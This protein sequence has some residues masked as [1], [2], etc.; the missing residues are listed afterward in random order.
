MKR[1]KMKQLFLLISLC[2]ASQAMAVCSSPIARSNFSS[3]QV[4]TSTR[5]N[6]ELNTAY[7]RANELPGDC[8]TTGT[9]TTTQIL[10]ET[11][12]SA[13]ILNGT[14]ANADISASA[15]IAMS[16]IA[17]SVATVFENQITGTDGGTFTLGAWRTRTL[18]TS[19]DPDS[20][21]TA[22]SSNKFTLG[23][24][25]YLIEGSAP[26]CEVLGH[27][28]KLYNVTAAGDELTGSSEYA[29]ATASSTC[30]RS[31]FSG[32]VLIVSASEFEVRHYSN[33][34]KATNGF[35]RASSIALTNEIYTTVR[36]I[37]IK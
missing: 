19:S 6:T 34:T 13:D 16:K 20:I 25:L 3:L 2:F 27:K 36:I 21:V 35:G 1:N 23:A 11:I 24:G 15:A 12:A 30:S 26:A 18:V 33:G 10:N 7:T 14:I 37:K 22:L 32:L 8:I 17:F 29:D 9:V 31:E 4:L 5:L 28:A